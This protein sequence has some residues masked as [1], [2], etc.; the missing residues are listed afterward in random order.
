MPL[1]DVGPLTFSELLDRMFSIYR[2][3]FLILLAIA[4]TPFVILFVAGALMGGVVG[5]IFAL[6]P[7]ASRIGVAP[8]SGL[9]ALLIIPLVIAILICAVLASTGTVAAVWDIQLG[10][11]PGI[12]ASYRVAWRCLWPAI[13]AAILSGL[14]VMAGFILLIIPGIIVY[15]ALSLTNPIIVAEDAGGAESLGRSWELTK[16]YRWKILGAVFVTSAISTVITYAIQI[17]LLIASALF[18]AKNSG[19]PLWFTMIQLAGS[20]L[21]NVLGAPLLAIALCLIYYDARVRK[22]GFDLQRMIDALPQAGASV[23]PAPAIS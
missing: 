12:R 10:R 14:A 15:L 17:P 19:P 5:G 11:K 7:N 18:V 16:G 21:G 23:P 4:G 13:A 9:I 8:A 20:L 1:A 6:A 3:Y 2:N 22:E